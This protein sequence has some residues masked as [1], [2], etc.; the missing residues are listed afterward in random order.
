MFLNVIFSY[1]SQ[2][3]SDW[4]REAPLRIENIKEKKQYPITIVINNVIIVFFIL[5]L[6]LLLKALYQVRQRPEV[7]YGVVCMKL[8]LGEDF[9]WRHWVYRRDAFHNFYSLD[10]L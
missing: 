5:L 7:S 1:D 8:D 9:F 4:R 3:V 2:G 10:D 6:H